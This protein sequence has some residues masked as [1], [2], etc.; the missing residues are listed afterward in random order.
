MSDL[1]ADGHKLDI[2]PLIR[3]QLD[4]APLIE[5]TEEQIKCGFRSTVTGRFG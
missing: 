1:P 2:N 3:A 4:S 5:A